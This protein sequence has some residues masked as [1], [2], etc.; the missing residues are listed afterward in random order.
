MLSY[1]DYATPAEIA[2]AKDW[3]H[4]MIW[5]LGEYKGKIWGLS[6][7]QQATALVW[8]KNIFKEV[9]LDPEKPPKTTGDLDELAKKLTT[10]DARGNIDR[11]GFLPTETWHWFT[12]FG[13]KFI[14]PDTM[15]ITANDPA[16]VRA[17]EWMT[18]YSK[19]Y[20]VTKVVAF[21]QGL[22]SERAGI[23][24]PFIAQKF[25]M[26]II[27]GPW[28]IGDFKKYAPPDFSYGIVA[29]PNPPGVTGNATWTYGD[30]TIVPKGTKHPK[31]AWK[32]VKFTGGAEG[33]KDLYTKVLLW[34]GR[35]INVPV[36]TQML[37]Y[38]ALLENFKEYPAYKFLCDLLLDPNTRVGIPP[39]T[40][41]G[42]FYSSRLGAAVEKAR[43]LQVPPKQALDDLTREV[44][45]EQDKYFK[46]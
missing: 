21:Q 46:K 29:S 26:Q 8:N 22:A 4:P 40:P 44:Q 9:G 12:V 38:P 11:M 17:L 39:K 28:K 24:E 5:K 31:E 33:N 13:G 10:F 41:V 37:D 1:E 43:L 18:S 35:P 14:D 36:S 2:K 27:G 23:L 16:N 7:W 42:V 19:K 30:L 34:G 3:Y 32:F 20:D 25:A 6:Y 45:A 15:K